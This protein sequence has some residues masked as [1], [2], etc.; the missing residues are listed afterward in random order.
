MVCPIALSKELVTGLTE[1]HTFLFVGCRTQ[2]RNL[3]RSNKLEK[4]HAPFF[5]CDSYV[6][7][8]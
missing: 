7:P 2:G 1:R 4:R 6:S 5:G 8:K 3:K